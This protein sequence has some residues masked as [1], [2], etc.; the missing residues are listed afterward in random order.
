MR[1]VVL[2]VL[3]AGARVASADPKF[4]YGKK[5]E[6]K[7]VKGVEWHA[8]AEGGIV[9]TTGNS[10]T[11]TA[12]GGFKVSRKTGANKLAIEASGA[13]ART[14]V[15]VLNDL[16]GNGMVDDASEITSADAGSAE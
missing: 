8:T 13:Y 2:G 7:D 1:L 10:E 5:D 14:S 15:R 12:S 16:N 11:T 4:E 3:I 6:L 9:L